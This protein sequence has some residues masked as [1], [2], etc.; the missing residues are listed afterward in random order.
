MLERGCCP[1][2]SWWNFWSDSTCSSPFICWSR[3]ICSHQISDVVIG[4]LTRK[5]SLIGT[6]KPWTIPIQWNHVSSKNQYN[7]LRYFLWWWMCRGSVLTT[8]HQDEWQQGASQRKSWMTDDK[9]N[10]NQSE[11][12]SWNAKGNDYDSLACTRFSCDKWQEGRHDV[13]SHTPWSWT[14]ESD[15]CRQGFPPSSWR[16]VFLS[17]AQCKDTSS[18]TVHSLARSSRDWCTIVQEVSFS[19]RGYCLEKSGTENGTDHY[20]PVDAKCSN[21]EKH[22]GNSWVVQRPWS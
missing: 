22:L 10:L 13:F 1:I 12:E 20:C 9:E 3:A 16:A 14:K 19:T 18:R 5:S 15:L 11:H 2:K 21:G 4:F 6:I 8:S 7:L 17:N